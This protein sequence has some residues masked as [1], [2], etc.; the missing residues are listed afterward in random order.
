[1]RFLIKII[2]YKKNLKLQVRRIQSLK[3]LTIEF[4]RIYDSA[5]KKKLNKN[6]VKT[7]IVKFMFAFNIKLNFT[8]LYG[9]N[10][11]PQRFLT[12]RIF[13]SNLIM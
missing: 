3:F 1:M 5:K 8:Y 2:L 7:R 4:D 12:Y 9:S 10:V 11:N 6:K 13:G